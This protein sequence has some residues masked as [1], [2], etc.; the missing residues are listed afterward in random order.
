MNTAYFLVFWVLLATSYG[1]VW[2]KSGDF[3]IHQ[4]N[5]STQL[6]WFHFSAFCMRNSSSVNFEFSFP[7]SYSPESL[8]LYPVNDS[9]WEDI[10]KLQTCEEKTS[11]ADP[12]ANNII[13]LSP[14]S[15]WS[16]CMERGDDISCV[17]GRTFRSVRP[18]CWRFVVANC[19]S[20][21]GLQL[22]FKLNITDGDYPVFPTR[23]PMTS[24]VTSESAWTFTVIVY[25][26]GSVLAFMNMKL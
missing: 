1:D 23:A 25:G 13:P 14:S 20:T 9:T 10:K 6:N 3:Y 22:N 7:T 19:N 26:L 15:P 24:G 21:Q 4:G 2:Q 12:Q 18:Q 17:L 8:Y 5:V 16:G 11:T